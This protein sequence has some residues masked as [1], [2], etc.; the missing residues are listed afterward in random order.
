MD[1]RVHF[2]HLPKDFKENLTLRAEAIVDFHH[3]F[4]SPEDVIH[5]VSRINQS[6][7]IS[8][9]Q[10]HVEMSF[11]LNFTSIGVHLENISFFLKF[12]LEIYIQGNT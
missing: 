11:L 6:H 7:T 12:F 4:G 2:S 9:N 3:N 10:K 1:I 8:P 5:H